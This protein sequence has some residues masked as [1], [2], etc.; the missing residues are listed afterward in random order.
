[1]KSLTLSP[2]PIVIPGNISLGFEANVA[3][4]EDTPLPV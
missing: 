4:L 3:D 2:D 1:V